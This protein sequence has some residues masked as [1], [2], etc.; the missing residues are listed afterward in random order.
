MSR[1]LRL[2][3]GSNLGCANTCIQS[4][5]Q[6]VGGQGHRHHH[7]VIM[8]QFYDNHTGVMNDC[9]SA[10]YA[11]AET[12]SSVRDTRLCTIVP[13]SW[14]RD[15]NASKDEYRKNECFKVRPLRPSL[16]QIHI[17]EHALQ[18]SFP[19]FPTGIFCF[20]TWF[21]SRRRPWIWSDGFGDEFV[22]VISVG[23]IA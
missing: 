18:T 1:L 2:I 19:R 12:R 15:V 9:P 21:C 10:K 4:A 8:E 13:W 20:G 5:N 22:A 17:R 6:Q 14:G 11:N 7:R 3:L 23:T 16:V